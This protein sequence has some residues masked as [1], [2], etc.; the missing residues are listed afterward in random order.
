[1]KIAFVDFKI[2]V[3]IVVRQAGNFIVND[4]VY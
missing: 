4:N 3:Y 1:L 2:F